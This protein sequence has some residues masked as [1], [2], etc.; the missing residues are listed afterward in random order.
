MP[1]SFAIH[2][3]PIL[4]FAPAI[5]DWE[6]TSFRES[7]QNLISTGLPSI[8]SM[9]YANGGNKLRDLA[10]ASKNIFRQAIHQA[11]VIQKTS[12][13]GFSGTAIENASLG[14][15]A[16]EISLRVASQAL[17]YFWFSVKQL[18]HFIIPMLHRL[19]S[20]F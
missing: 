4:R 15:K 12:D 5:S 14:L 10:E 1:G 3:Y 7:L 19:D 18:R 8:T 9:A 6:N 11:S 2:F 16:A 17:G 13:D 20:C